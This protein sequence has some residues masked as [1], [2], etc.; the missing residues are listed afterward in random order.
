MRRTHPHLRRATR[1]ARLHVRRR[2]RAGAG[3]RAARHRASG[4]RVGTGQDDVRSSTWR[5]RFWR[6]VRPAG[7]AESAEKPRA[8]G[9]CS[10]AALHSVKRLRAAVRLGAVDAAGDGLR[11]GG[12]WMHAARLRRTEARE[13]ARSGSCS[14]AR[15]ATTSSCSP[16]ACSPA[17]ASPVVA[18][19]VLVFSDHRGVLDDV[20]ARRSARELRR[21]PRPGSAPSRAPT[22]ATTQGRCCPP[23]AGV[24]KRSAARSTRRWRRC[25]T[26]TTWS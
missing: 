8:M 11:A 9:P 4:Q 14:S 7:R 26:T 3:R 23:A 22:S 25:A 17:P 2:R 13:L 15:I 16:A 18:S 5:R 24:P 10:G 19:G 12:E 21:Q 20:A 6:L 1:R